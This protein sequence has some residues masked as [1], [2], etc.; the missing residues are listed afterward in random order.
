MSVIAIATLSCQSRQCDRRAPVKGCVG[1]KNKNTIGIL[2]F[3]AANQ[4]C[5]ELVSVIAIATPLCQSRQCDRRAPVKGCVGKK[6][7]I[8]SVFLFLSLL[9]EIATLQFYFY[10]PQFVQS[11]VFLTTVFH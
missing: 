2:I 8:P 6:I 4:T 7:R 5:S 9:Y 10:S 3:G 11:Q 1:K